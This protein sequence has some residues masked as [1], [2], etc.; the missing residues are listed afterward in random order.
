[1]YSLWYCAER[2]EGVG[3][4]PVD[5]LGSVQSDA[6]VFRGTLCPS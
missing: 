6:L 1:M 2:S 3:A 5:K 4:V